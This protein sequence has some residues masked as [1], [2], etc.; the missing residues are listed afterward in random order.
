MRRTIPWLMALAL[1]GTLS[2]PS[3]HAQNYPTRPV[4]IITLTAPVDLSWSELPKHVMFLPLTIRTVD[5]L[6]QYREPESWYTVGRM[7]GMTE[8]TVRVHSLDFKG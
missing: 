7:L 4:R 8:G 2:A 3:A 1:I 6:A 5:Y